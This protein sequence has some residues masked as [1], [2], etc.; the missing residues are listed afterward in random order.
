LQISGIG[1]WAWLESSWRDFQLGLIDA[2]SDSEALHPGFQILGKS[3]RAGGLAG[4]R[5]GHGIKL[6]IGQSEKLDG[7]LDRRDSPV[8][9]R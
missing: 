4:W 9:G 6:Q 1:D 8:A 2:E 7:F 3:V 5:L